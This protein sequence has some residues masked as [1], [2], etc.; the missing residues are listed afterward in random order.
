MLEKSS[1]E[2]VYKAVGEEDGKL[3][4]DIMDFSKSGIWEPYCVALLTEIHDTDALS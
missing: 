4:R 2:L 1:R 3:V